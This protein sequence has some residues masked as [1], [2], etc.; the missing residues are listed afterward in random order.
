ME[1]QQYIKDAA[2][3]A[4]E[5]IKNPVSKSDSFSLYQES[6]ICLE[7]LTNANMTFPYQAFKDLVE[8]TLA[9]LEENTPNEEYHYDVELIAKKMGKEWTNEKE[10]EKAI[11]SVKNYFKRLMNDFPSF[12]SDFQE[13]AKRRNL[14]AIPTIE[15]ISKKGAYLN[16]YYLGYQKVNFD[17]DKKE[18]NFKEKSNSEKYNREIKKL[19]SQDEFKF[20]ECTEESENINFQN[21]QNFEVQYSTEN[22]KL[23]LFDWRYNYELSGKR[24]FF[25]VVFMMLVF[26]GI[27][28]FVLWSF[29]N[30][31]GYIFS[32][33]GFGFS[34]SLLLS[35]YILIIWPAKRKWDYITKRIIYIFP[36]FFAPSRF[37]ETQLECV[38]TDKIREST[39]RP[40]RKIQLVSYWATCPICKEKLQRNVRIDVSK[41]GKEFHNRLIGRCSESP[42]EHIYSFD[43]ITRIG[44][45]L[46]K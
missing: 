34:Y 42:T 5:F 29:P 2:L 43:H 25:D 1:N 30:N 15:I 35:I 11:K 9:D 22:V 41:G 4:L 31:I 21:E 12:I 19:N 27:I 46:R 6:K 7:S 28:Y 32:F 36:P 44:K 3:C 8:L 40:I 14:S 20:E 39:G 17:T 18:D 10:R 13:I 33:K 38:A 23:N 16:I 26:L 37:T 24:M 45:P